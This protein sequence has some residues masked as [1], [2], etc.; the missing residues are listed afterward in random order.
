MQE[1]KDFP[2]VSIIAI[3]HNHAAYVI[4]T[5][6]SIRNQTYPNIEL[7]II[8]NV[9]D[10]CEAIIL[11]WIK[12]HE[13][14]CFFIQNM[15]PKTVTQNCNIGL[16]NCN[17]KYFQVIA[18]DDV[19]LPGKIERQVQLFENLDDRYACVYS[20]MNYINE[21]GI[22]ETSETLQERKQRKWGTRLFP[23]GNLKYELSLLSFIPAPGALLK[24]DIIK[25]LNGFDEK[26]L[27]EDWPMWVKLCKNNYQFKGLNES[28]VKYRLLPSSLG[29]S[30]KNS[31]YS[32][33]LIDFYAD[34]I[35]FFNFRFRNTFLNFNGAV[36][37]VDF[38]LKNLFL[39]IKVIAKTRKLNYT[40]YL[41]KYILR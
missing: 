33:S 22:S 16:L 39:I 31:P 38:K 35:D 36:N 29:R 20:D 18:C 7:I 37:S 10:E 34:N 1:I 30:S 6:E 21:N 24:T 5:L 2:L 8:N 26:Y 11:N 41:L 27:F 23:S 3:C 4:E 15:Q 13:M 40:K 25:R 19:L 17:G 28:L 12:E 14:K 9:K 32:N